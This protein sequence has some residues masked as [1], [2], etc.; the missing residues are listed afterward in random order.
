MSLRPI[1]ALH[2]VDAGVRSTLRAARA[3]LTHAVRRE[4][5]AGAVRQIGR[6]LAFFLPALLVERVPQ[7]SG[8][9][10]SIAAAAA[11][12]FAWFVCVNI[13]SAATKT[14]LATLGSPVTL[15]RGLMFAVIV[16]SAIP[17]WIPQLGLSLRGTVTLAVMSAVLV[18]GWEALARRYLTPATRLMLVGPRRAC[19]DVIRELSLHCARRFQLVG[20]VDD[21]EHRSDPLV[22]GRTVELPQILSDVRPDLVALV[23]GCNR[24]EAFAQ[25]VD[26]AE[27]GFR[28]LELAQFYEFA[29]GRLPVRDLSPAWFMSVLH[30][31]QQPYS[32]Y[33]KR[34]SD[35]VGA[36]LLALLFA[37]LFPL[38]ALVVRFTPGP[39][40]LKQV[41]IGEHGREFRI[42]KFRTMGVDAELP[43]H[44]VWASVGDPRVTTAGAVMRRLRLDELPQLLNVLRGEMSIVG[45]RPER[46][47]FIRDLQESIPS[48]S[49]RLLVK[50]GITGW[51]QVNVGYTSDAAG[52]LAK[53]S[54]D[55]WYIRHRNL[56]VDLAI[57]CRTLGAV[58]RGEV[59]ERQADE[60]D[61]I[62]T[63]LHVG[64]M[65]QMNPEGVQAS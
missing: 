36:T 20:I 25:L 8:G 21:E 11:I 31:Y 64:S 33:V 9:T 60:L 58:M 63:L 23:P 55:L 12:A 54:Y 7:A 35:I 38:L 49:R 15:V 30:L 26:S 13:A 6:A 32:T 40:F 18:A 24:L 51:A 16:T 45:P 29:F 52:S 57:C 4:P 62:A 50:P 34:F 43:G 10:Q 27:Y 39:C 19:D 56:T 41:R 17:L 44:A 37:P 59:P 42:Y 28:V 46:P 53:L 2:A 61:P 5:D 48:W 22:R 1:E 14:T 3:P 65:S 47:E